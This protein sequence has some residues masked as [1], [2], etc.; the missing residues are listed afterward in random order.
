MKR[1][2]KRISVLVLAFLLAVSVGTA[3]RDLRADET[4]LMKQI[5]ANKKIIAESTKLIEKDKKDDQALYARGSA[6]LTLGQIYTAMY[7]PKRTTEQNKIIKGLCE[8]AVTDFTVVIDLR[9]DLTQ[10]HIMRGMAYGQMGLS[11]AAIADFTHVI[12]VDKKNASAY[13]ARGREYWEMGEYQKAK[14]DY[15]KAVEF[16]PRWKDNFYR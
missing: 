13:Y 8:D 9:P 10:A 3:V 1:A 7:S 5:D 2:L 16:D 11:H 14:E 12:E 4:T 6:Y 15:D